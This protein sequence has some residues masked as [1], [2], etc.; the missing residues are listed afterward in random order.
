[1]NLLRNTSIGWAIERVQKTGTYK[2]LNSN[3][4][5]NGIPVNMNMVHKYEAGSEIHRL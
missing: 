3:S 1:V 4:S 2:N 5:E